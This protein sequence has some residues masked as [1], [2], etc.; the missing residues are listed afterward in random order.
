MGLSRYRLTPLDVA[1]F[2][3]ARPFSAEDSSGARLGSLVPTQLAVMG[4]LRNVILEES[5]TTYQD[6]GAGK[7]PASAGTGPQTPG[8]L[9]VGAVLWGMRQGQ[10]SALYYPSPA[11]LVQIGESE[12]PG[13]LAPVNGGPKTNLPATLKLTRAAQFT[14]EH[15]LRLLPLGADV[16][17]S[18]ETKLLPGDQLSHYLMGKWVTGLLPVSKFRRKKRRSVSYGIQTPRRRKMPCSIRSSSFV[19][20]VFP[21]A[22]RP[23]SHL[24][25]TLAP[26]LYPRF[27]GS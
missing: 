18:P 6:F 27:E 21:P 8:T 16:A 23:T 7:A 4:A 24:P 12:H 13:Y 14:R 10:V 3:D 26:K 19:C 9:R 11:D 20:P 2:R 5:G 17:I 25:S 1:L 22:C 15:E